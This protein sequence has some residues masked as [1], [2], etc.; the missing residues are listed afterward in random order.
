MDDNERIEAM[1][2][3]AHTADLHLCNVGWERLDDMTRNGY[4][5]GARRLFAALQAYDETKPRPSATLPAVTKTN[6][7]N[8]N[9]VKP[10]RKKS[11][12][13]ARA[14]SN[15]LV[16]F[17]KQLI[18]DG[19]PVKEIVRS[20]PGCSEGQVYAIAEGKCY[21]DVTIDDGPGAA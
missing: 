19:V 21:V 17:V 1:A 3:A 15:S 20:A 11:P 14:L 7:E 18:R 4:R 6:L 5:E 8:W 13:Q 16:R 12:N 2:R 9:D 10:R